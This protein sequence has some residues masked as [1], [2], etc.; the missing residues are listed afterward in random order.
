M[1]NE[2]EKCNFCRY[3]D[4]NFC[5]YYSNLGCH[6]CCTNYSKFKPNNN[7]IIETAREKDLSVADL[8]ALITLNN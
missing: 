2:F 7:K 1:Y 6:I 8:I 4:D 5:T 3:Y